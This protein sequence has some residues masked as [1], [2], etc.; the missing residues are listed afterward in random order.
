MLL[1]SNLMTYRN[2]Q[3]SN[4]VNKALI[5]KQLQKKK[6]KKFNKFFNHFM[7]S[8]AKFNEIEAINR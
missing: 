2:Q 3:V 4:G 8:N 1:K 7:L 5:A 6:K